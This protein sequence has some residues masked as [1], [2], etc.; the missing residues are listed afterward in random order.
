MITHHGPLLEAGAPRTLKG[1][2]APMA[3]A[4][5]INLKSKQRNLHQSVLASFFAF[6]VSVT[7]QCNVTEM[8]DLQI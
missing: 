5:M 4:Q 1:H 8:V 3:V 2:T 7:M 6:F